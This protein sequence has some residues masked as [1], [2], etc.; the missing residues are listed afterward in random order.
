MAH[1][2][3]VKT[4]GL[5]DNPFM[6]GTGMNTQM[7]QMLGASSDVPQ[8]LTGRARTRWRI[9]GSTLHSTH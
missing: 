6:F 1:V 9:A 8:G 2:N 4:P 7:G 5:G 3:A